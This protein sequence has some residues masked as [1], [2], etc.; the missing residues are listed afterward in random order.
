WIGRDE[1]EGDERAERRDPEGREELPAQRP[2]PRG[3]RV[4]QRVPEGATSGAPRAVNREVR[5][6][7]QGFEVADERAIERGAARDGE[8]RDGAAVQAREP[9]E[10]LLAERREAALE[11]ALAQLVQLVPLGLA[12]A[13]KLDRAR[14]SV[15]ARHPINP[16]RLMCT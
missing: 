11:H 16:R 4:E 13:A 15:L 9:L 6:R 2:D 8:A 1:D 7:G 5:A 10:L 3:E 12:L 14:C